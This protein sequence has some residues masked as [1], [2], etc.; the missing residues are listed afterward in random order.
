MQTVA[1]MGSR[2]DGPRA[3]Q[4]PVHG[5][6]QPQQRDLGNERAGP[7]DQAVEPGGTMLCDGNGQGFGC[8]TIGGMRWRGGK[9]VCVVVVVVVV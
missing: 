2:V 3:L 4:S 6:L 9:C 5:R 1:I 8:E 7:T